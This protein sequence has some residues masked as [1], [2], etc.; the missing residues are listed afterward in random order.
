MLNRWPTWQVLGALA[1]DRLNPGR[2]MVARAQMAA[3][4]GVGIGDVPD[5][6]WS[7]CELVDAGVAT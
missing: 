4:L 3:F 5:R 7:R 1:Q 2:A 6:L